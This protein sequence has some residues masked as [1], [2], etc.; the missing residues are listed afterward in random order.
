MGGNYGAASGLQTYNASA[1]YSFDLAS[2]TVL[3]LGLLDLTSHGAGFNALTLSA[4]LNDQAT[5]FSDS[6]TSL[7]AAQ[8][9]FDDHAIDLGSL[10]A[11]LQTIALTYSLTANNAQGAGFSYIVAA[12]PV[13]E[14]STWLTLVFG[15]FALVPA[16]RRR[17]G[18]VWSAERTR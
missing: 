17:V 5:I 2:T 8:A 1:K 12:A 11:G 18:A 16:A 10:A 6:F 15:L 3:T 4:T 7:A 13:P 14:P 9:Y